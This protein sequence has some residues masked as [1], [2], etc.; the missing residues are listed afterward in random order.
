M[1]DSFLN[2][3]DSDFEN[4]DYSDSNKKVD[5]NESVKIKNRIAAK[6]FREKKNAGL[7]KLEMENDFLVREVLNLSYKVLKIKTE[8]KML[9]ENINF[10]QSFLHNIMK[11][12]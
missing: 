6:K 9:E 8:N 5:R 11:K 4:S 3:N 2:Y 10:F 7:I 1:K 12:K